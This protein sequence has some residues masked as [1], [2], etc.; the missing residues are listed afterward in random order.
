MNS[1][2]PGAGVNL[3]V[4]QSFLACSIRSLREDTKFHKM[5]RGPSNAA[6]PRSIRR[7]GRVCSHRDTAARIEDQKPRPLECLARDLDLSLDDI[8]CPLL[9]VAIKRRAHSRGERYFCVEPFRERSHGR[10]PAE[11]GD[12]NHPGPHTVVLETLAVRRALRGLRSDERC[13]ASRTLWPNTNRVA[14]APS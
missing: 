4:F 7:A 12:G 5:K 9:R 1:V 8:D 11:S 14:Q 3:P 13:H 6:P 2:S 10:R